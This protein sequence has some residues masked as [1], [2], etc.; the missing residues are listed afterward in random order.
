MTRAKKCGVLY[1]RMTTSV[2]SSPW[3]SEFRSLL[4]EASTRLRVAAPFIKLSAAEFMHGVLGNPPRCG[5]RLQIL[6]RLTVPELLSGATDLEAIQVMARLPTLHAISVEIRALSNLHAKIY[7]VDDRVAVVTSANLTPGG[8][9]SNAELGIRLSEP[10][11]VHDVVNWFDAAWAV[12]SIVDQRVIDAFKVHLGTLRVR[13][14]VE[15]IRTS[16]DVG[17]SRTR[18][19]LIRNS[20]FLP[21]PADRA[22]FAAGRA[23]GSTLARTVVPLAARSTVLASSSDGPQLD[24]EEL[25]LPGAVSEVLDPDPSVLVQ[26]LLTGDV[27]TRRSARRHLRAL[28]RLNPQ[29]VTDFAEALVDAPH[30]EALD[31]LDRL[32]PELDVDAAALISCATLRNPRLHLWQDGYRFLN[33]HDHALANTILLE[34]LLE[35]R[36]PGVTTHVASLRKARALHR[37]ASLSLDELRS[38][39]AERLFTELASGSDS[40]VGEA[41]RRA[42]QRMR[43]KALRVA[44]TAAAQDP[45]TDEDCDPA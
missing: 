28:A 10:N 45:S 44:T 40:V 14:V 19:E 13:S 11:A 25:S 20:R 5:L 18:T 43:R 17:V 8:L 26:D 31:V 21:R 39:D 22:E 6:T 42:R 9:M 4:L 16:P 23:A 32:L 34:I 29:A 24:A 38:F 33:R 12:A 41:A 15:Q 35:P 3:T 30:S 37:L 27:A 36:K 7:C 2:I 1:A